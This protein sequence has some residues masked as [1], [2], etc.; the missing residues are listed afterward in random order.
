MEQENPFAPPRV[1]LIEAS[2]VS[3]PG[4]SASHLR[5]LGWLALAHFM[6]SLLGMA[7]SVLGEALEIPFLITLEQWLGAVFALLGAYLLLRFKA[8]LVVRFGATGLEWPVYLTI[9]FGLVAQAMLVVFDGV[10]ERLGLPMAGLFLVLAMLGAAT[11]W[12]GI[13]LLGLREGG[14]L[15][16]TLAWLYMISGGM[17]ISVLLMLLATLPLLA[18]QFVLMLIFFRAAGEAR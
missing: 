9:L 8:W 16:R 7:L 14:G 15:L 12:L 11:L 3:L 13:C 2:S 1:E 4:L 18:G 10:L 6:G 17:L 5:L